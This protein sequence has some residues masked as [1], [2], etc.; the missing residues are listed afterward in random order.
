LISPNYTIPL[1][2]E[3][4]QANNKLL[5]DTGLFSGEFKASL[6][7]SIEDFDTMM[8][9][10]I[11]SLQPLLRRDGALFVSI[12]KTERT[13]LEYIMDGVFGSD[14]HIEELIWA[15]NT[16][17]SQLPNYST[18]HEYVL[19]Y[20]KD[21]ITAEL[22]RNMFREPKPGYEEVMALV[23]EL[24]PE[25]PAIAEI[26]NQL[27]ALYEQHQIAYREEIEALGREFELEICL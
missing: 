24:N 26:E 8:H 27:R 4:L 15:M 19:V 16:N 3:F 20:A 17:N 21:R 1:T 13:I 2:V 7:A 18:N 25:F 22:D 12:D 11:A 10:R 5:V 6:I 23:A 14:N 9:D